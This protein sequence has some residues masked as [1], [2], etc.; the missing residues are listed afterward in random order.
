MSE[1]SYER[2]L[3]E[4]SYINV[5]NLLNDI[6]GKLKNE[7]LHYNLHCIIVFEDYEFI[8]KTRIPTGYKIYVIEDKNLNLFL[9]LIQDKVM[10]RSEVLSDGEVLSDEKKIIFVMLYKHLKFNKIYRVIFKL[11]LY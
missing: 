5:V 9:T 2:F 10:N 6:V 8:I 7:N 1:I 11:F 3:I 4:N